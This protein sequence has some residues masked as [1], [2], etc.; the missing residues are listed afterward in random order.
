MTISNRICETQ[1]D[2]IYCIKYRLS[3]TVRYIFRHYEKKYLQRALPNIQ[4]QSITQ[5]NRIRHLLTY[6]RLCF[7]LLRDVL[8]NYRD[9]LHCVNLKFE[10][11]HIFYI[12][13]TLTKFKCSPRTYLLSTKINVTIK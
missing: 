11:L 13:H 7:L 2:G 10:D 4:Y 1:G 8:Y 5:G 6:V 3:I 12:K 9:C